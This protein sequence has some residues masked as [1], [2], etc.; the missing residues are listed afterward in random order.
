[1][2]KMKKVSDDEKKKFK[3]DARRIIGPA[4]PRP[5]PGNKEGRAS[6]F[7]KGSRSNGF[8]NDF[9]TKMFPVLPGANITLPSTRRQSIT[10]QKKKTGAR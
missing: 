3:E 2:A 8:S 7:Y 5:V 1:M 10:G 6:E 9:L 4:T